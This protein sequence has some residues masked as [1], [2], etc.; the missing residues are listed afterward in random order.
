MGDEMGDDDMMGADAAD[1]GDAPEGRE[2]KESAEEAYLNALKM[3]KE[4]QS[5][6]Q[7]NKAVLKKAF[8]TLKKFKTEKAQQGAHMG[9]GSQHAFDNKAPK[10]GAPKPKAPAKKMAGPKKGAT[11]GGGTTAA[12][13]K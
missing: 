13:F 3:V 11:M 8:E 7:V 5:D 10:Q 4:A 1:G 9:G 12:A 6:G 2:M